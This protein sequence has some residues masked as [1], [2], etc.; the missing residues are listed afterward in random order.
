MIPKCMDALLAR[1]EHNFHCT[2][3]KHLFLVPSRAGKGPSAHNIIFA[4]VQRVWKSVNSEHV[5]GLPAR[6]QFEGRDGL[7]TVQLPVHAYSR[8][9]DGKELK[10]LQKLIWHGASGINDLI[11]QGDRTG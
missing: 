2:I 6:P 5:F 1:G 10:A 7:W 8:R 9:S 3:C 4:F 11:K